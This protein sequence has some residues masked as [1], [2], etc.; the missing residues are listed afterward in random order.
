LCNGFDDNCDGATDEGYTVDVPG[1]GLLKP[2]DPCQWGDCTSV[3]GCAASGGGLTCLGCPCPAELHC[4]GEEVTPVLAPPNAKK[5]PYTAS[6]GFQEVTAQLPLQALEV[7][8]GAT[9]KIAYGSSGMAIDAD[10]DGHLDQWWSDGLGHAVLLRR[11]GN[12]S[13]AAQTVLDAKS[14]WACVAATDGDGDGTPELIAAGGKLAYLVRQA[15]GSYLDLGNALGVGLPAVA[16]GGEGHAQSVLP[17]DLNSDGLLDLAVGW[18]SCKP[19]ERGVLAFVNRGA[20]GYVEQGLQLGFSLVTP[21]WALLSSDFTGDGRGDLLVLNEGCSPS[22]M[23]LYV[24]Q[25]PGST[26]AYVL[27]SAPPE[28]TAPAGPAFAN[29]MGAAVADVNG[30]GVQD[31]L[32]TNEELLGFVESGGKVDPFD[33]RQPTPPNVDSLFFLLSQPGGGRLNAGKQA[34]VWAPLSETRKPMIAWS[35]AWSDLDHDGALDLLLSHGHDAATWL[36]QDEGSMRPVAFRNDGTQEFEDHSVD[37]GLPVSHPGRSLVVADLD[38]DGDDDLLAG[39]QAVPPRAW[40]NAIVHGGKDLRLRLVGKASNPWGLGARVEV[41]TTQR[42]VF[43]EHSVQAV[44]QAMA[45]PESHVALRPGEQALAMQVVWPS[46][47]VQQ[48]TLPPEGGSVTLTEPPLFSLSTRWSP[49]GKTPVVVKAQA[50]CA[51]ELAAGAQGQ[52]QGPTAC[53]AQG[54]SRTWQGGGLGPGE[55]VVVITCK[56]K[57]W[58]I[59][60]RIFH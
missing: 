20:G 59:R 18:F 28:F 3:V 52:W 17:V 7:D 29:P 22:G 25:P 6:G 19:P 36:L 41:K 42:S 21:P 1:V 16:P 15:D 60:P 13:Y 53:D 5:L 43:L 27:Q 30:D 4:P 39:G 33:K 10:A 58:A 9:L 35:A 26:P 47:E 44:S 56:G 45:V 57:P 31:Y 14:N 34:G 50:G 48:A 40:R 11:T 8:T 55:D 2:G 51:I 54:C 37:W 49:G 46:R 12:W 24:Q 32:I 23:G 38:G